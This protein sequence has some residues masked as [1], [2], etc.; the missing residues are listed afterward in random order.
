MDVQRLA[1]ACVPRLLLGAQ[2][3][4]V[5]LAARL[6]ADVLDVAAA[7]AEQLAHH[8]EVG[9]RVVEA[10]DEDFF[11]FESPNNARL[12]VAVRAATRNYRH[13]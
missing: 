4:Q 5:S 8:T 7:R 12:H 2:T 11:F 6:G 13:G 10:S 3:S 1:K 9:G